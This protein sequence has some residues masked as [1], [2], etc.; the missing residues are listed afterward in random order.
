M[1]SQVVMAYV[2]QLGVDPF[3]VIGLLFVLMVVDYRWIPET[4]LMKPQDQVEEMRK[5]E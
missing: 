2:R 3:L 5:M 4:H 1:G